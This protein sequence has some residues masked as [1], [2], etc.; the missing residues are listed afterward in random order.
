MDERIAAWAA[1]GA[2]ALTG[3]PDGPPLGPPRPLVERLQAFGAGLGVDP[4]QL[5]GERAAV[6][7]L[8]R[9]G[10]ISCGGS[11][12]L[13]R[14]ADGWLA[15]TLAR[16]DDIAAVPAWLEVAGPDLDED[17][18]RTIASVVAGRPRELLEARATL[19]GLPVSGLPSEPPHGRGT[20]PF[21]SLPVRASPF[22]PQARAPADP[23]VV[24]DLSSLWAGPL[25]GQLLQSAGARV[26]KVEST[27]RPDGARQGPATFFDLLNGGKQSVALELGTPEG[28]GALRRLIAASDVV[29]EASRPR[30]FAQLGVSA[31]HELQAERGPA[32]WISITGHGRDGPAGDR[33]G[34]G[35][36]A[37]VAG[38]L[39]VCDANGP[40]FCAD[41]IADPIT[42]IVAASATRIALHTGQRWLVDIAMARVAADLAGPTVD[43]SAVDVMVAPPSARHVLER[44]APLGRD[45]RAVL[46]ALE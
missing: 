2:M 19:L 44:A 38:G 26:I 4:L 32:V 25:C 22:G 30:A 34:F 16:D 3:R 21:D 43:A 8:T 36:D 40:C 33:V 42:G 20:P 27:D 5:L 9:R 11:T 10:D 18:W 6:A 24:I 17:P 12:R 39:V 41:A 7:G 46:D 45:T 14:A 15:V 1:S 37:A 23:P 28:L 29:I 35:D 31:S 13:V